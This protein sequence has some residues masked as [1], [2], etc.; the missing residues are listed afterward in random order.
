M[1][2]KI[3]ATPAGSAG[4]SAKESKNMQFFIIGLAGF[5]G[6]FVILFAGYGV[7]RVYAQAA[8]DSGTRVVSEVL[9]LPLA[10]INGKTIL[11]SDYLSDLKA[12]S[13]LRDFDKKSGGQSASLT[14]QQMSDQVIWRL[15]NNIFINDMARNID[16]SAE[17]KDIDDLKAQMLAQFE[18]PA[19]AESELMNRYGW[20][21]TVYEEKVIRPYVLQQKL[22]EKIATD[23]K[24]R[25][26]V[27]AR[28]SGVLELIKNGANF[29]EM[30]AKYGEDGTAAK[31]GDLGWFAKGDMVAQFE[32]AAFA[33][34]EGELTQELVET[35]FG[36]HIIRVDDTRTEKIK[37]AAGKMVDT[38]QISARHIIFMFP[39]MEKSV[40]DALKNA[41][42]A[43]YVKKI[44][45]P[46]TATIPTV[47]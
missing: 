5:L 43:W 14:D 20:T 24:L 38:P 33:L 39:S 27:R 19:K 23:Q 6:V 40:S 1:E 42:I 22:A 15:A 41:D 13:T 10:K 45:N 28:A 16:I 37:D 32:T 36:Y 17:Q 21:M 3:N 25:E 12:I 8:N 4:G 29:E 30:A 26:E 35:P 44:S 18:S 31:G 46:L 11:Y 2:D 47:E 7:F 34:K 9:R